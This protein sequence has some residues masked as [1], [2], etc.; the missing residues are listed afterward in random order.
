[1]GSNHDKKMTKQHLFPTVWTGILAVCLTAA[2]T[3]SFARPSEPGIAE[4]EQRLSD[5]D[6]ELQQLA[7]CSM[8]SGAGTVGWRSSTHETPDQTEWIQI[9]LE[10]E[11]LIDQITLAPVIWRSTQN[12][13]QADGFPGEFTLKAGTA[14]D[15]NGI[16]V[17]SF[18]EQDQFLPR[19]AP[20]VIPIPETKAS[21]VR[22]E[23]TRLSPRAWD[24]KYVL[25]LSEFMVFSAEE[26]I[27]LQQPVTTSS[28]KEM[29]SDA[30][31]KQT[32]VDGYVPYLMNAASG[33]QSI[34]FMTP[35]DIED[36]SWIS[37]DLGQIRPLNR[38]HLHTLD[39]S[40]TIPQA[41]PTVLGIPGRLLIEGA[42]RPDFSDKVL[43]VDYQRKT[44]FDV[45][46]II[47]KRFPETECRYVRITSAAPYINEE[48]SLKRS[49]MGFAE[50]EL[51]SRGKNVAVGCSARLSSQQERRLEALT[52]G[53]N[54]YGNILSTRDWMEQL[55]L[56]HDLETERPFIV[57]KLQQRHERQQT[58]LT[59]FKGLAALLM[60]T[61]IFIVLID[62]MLRMRQVSRIKERL[63]ADLHDE[64]GA[65]IHSIG[66]LSDI[67]RQSINVPRQFEV[68][69][70]RI[71]ELTERTGTA[72]QH[73]TNMLEAENL[74]TDLAVDMRNSSDRI[75]TN[76]EHDLQITGEAYLAALSHRARIDLFLFY[77]ECLV[78]VCR[79]SHATQIKTRLIADARQI[80]L[81]ITD[82]GTGVT[83]TPKSLRRRARLLGAKLSVQSLEADGT[84]I[85]L[86]LKPKRWKFKR[87]T[88]R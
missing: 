9:D 56:R 34:A 85:H 79:H 72:I 35:P 75:T 60:T 3:P 67:A 24:G 80:N 12:H 19:I 74:Y 41:S 31:N 53:R 47:K 81:T 69:H 73:C 28:V 86:K 65:N 46:P 4:L 43:L 84:T 11:T 13:F 59:R 21:W 83:E 62:R 42:T 61:I 64:L 23:A 55:S 25:Q 22:L 48:L 68:S 37:I 15:T 77:K 20:L 29:L 32:L 63:A 76:L 70:Q 7:G 39:M 50:I 16:T 30:R 14:S 40:D 36:Q 58:M 78:N 45:G 52:D 26:N 5:I 6:T 10:Q 44:L 49:Q 71:R 18:S 88:I 38:I 1:M 17:A 27:A 57:E 54:L 66:L 8:R 51:F 82:N 33:E 87:E 2:T